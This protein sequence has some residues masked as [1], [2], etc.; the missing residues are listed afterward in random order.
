MKQSAEMAVQSSQE[1][2]RLSFHLTIEQIL[3]CRDE[4]GRPLGEL[5]VPAEER[6]DVPMRVARCPYPGSRQHHELPMNMSAFE[7]ISR[8]W[9]E[10]LEAIEYV[11]RAYLSRTLVPEP[12][13]ALNMEELWAVSSACAV[14]INFLLYRAHEPYRSGSLPTLAAVLYK[15]SLGI[16]SA[17]ETLAVQRILLASYEP[18]GTA[19][20]E[21]LSA[22]A[23]DF[24]LFISLTGVCAGPPALI[25]TS[26]NAFTEGQPG[27]LQAEGMRALFPEPGLLLDFAAEWRALR[28]VVLALLIRMHQLQRE[29]SGEWEMAGAHVGLR[30]GFGQMAA[31]VAGLEPEVRQQVVSALGAVVPKELRPAFSAAFSLET[32]SASPERVCQWLNGAD[33]ASLSPELRERLPRLLGQAWHLEEQAL[34][35]LGQVHARMARALGFSGIRRWDRSDLDECFGGSPLSL[36]AKGCGLSAAALPSS[37]AGSGDACPSRPA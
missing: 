29:L 4:E 15:V 32:A 27:A 2:R 12:N 19:T 10:L 36:L 16:F 18:T 31:M 35:L 37:C 28:I 7:Q 14:A 20:A 13:K 17:V 22:V 3:R 5:K 24:G 8:R 9:P 25:H 30:E 26:I 23:D 21:E 11:R 1:E 34:E 33:P 6:A